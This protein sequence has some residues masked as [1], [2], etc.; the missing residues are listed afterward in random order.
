[1]A[2]LLGYLLDLL[3]AILLG[4]VL[5]RTFQ[6]LFGPPSTPSSG[7]R[8]PASRG[9]SARTVHGETARDPACGMFVSTELSHRLTRDGKTLHF[10]SLECLER[11]RDRDQESGA[12]I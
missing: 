9:G 12:G 7:A 2:R 6:S 11:Y 1:M 3:V 4:R 5:T 10:C 8:D